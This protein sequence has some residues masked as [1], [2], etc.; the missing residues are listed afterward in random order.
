ML[1]QLEA[2]LHK[3]PAVPGMKYTWRSVDAQLEASPLCPYSDYPTNRLT[4]TRTS[5]DTNT[6]TETQTTMTNKQTKCQHTAPFQSIHIFLYEVRHPQRHAV[7]C[8]RLQSHQALSRSL[9]GRGTSK[10]GRENERGHFSLGPGVKLT[11]GLWELWTSHGSLICW[12]AGWQSSRAAE[13]QSRTDWIDEGGRIRIGDGDRNKA[14]Y[15]ETERERDREKAAD[16]S[17]L[18][19]PHSC[20]SHLIFPL[21]NF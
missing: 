10:G 1:P 12:I 9:V 15:C 21:T 11:G 4:Y 18:A 17:N 2:K 7:L 8:R 14:W 6:H 19:M 3:F 5:M 20:K 13:Q 16:K